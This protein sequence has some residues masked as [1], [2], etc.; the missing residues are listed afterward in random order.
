MDRTHIS[1]D[2]AELYPGAPGAPVIYAHLERSEAERAL[3]ALEGRAALVLLSCDWNRDLSPWPAPKAFK[4][5]EDFSGGA[6]EHLS[7]LCNITIPSAEE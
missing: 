3:P 1:L 4:G 5:G 6:D 7:T 2:G